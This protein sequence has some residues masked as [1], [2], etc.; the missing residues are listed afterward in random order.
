MKKNWT[1][2]PVFEN[3]KKISREQRDQSDKGPDLPEI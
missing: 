2:G 1:K 3:K